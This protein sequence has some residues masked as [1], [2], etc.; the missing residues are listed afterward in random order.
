MRGF[1][2]NRR[3]LRGLVLLL[4]VGLFAPIALSRPADVRAADQENGPIAAAALARLDTWG[5]QCW[6][7][8]QEVVLQ[9][10]GRR[11]GFDY[12]QGFFEAGA[13]EVSAEEAQNGDII[14][15]ADDAD[16]NP[17]AS[18]PGMHTAIVLK[19][20]GG[21]RFDAVDSNQNWD[22]WVNLR[23]GYDPYASAARYGLQVRIYRIPGG[24]PGAAPAAAGSNDTPLAS[25]DPATVAADGGC[26]N[27][28]SA[29]GL[30][31]S[32][33]D[34]LPEGTGV[35]ITGEPVSKDGFSWVPVSTPRANGL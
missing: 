26:L 23:Y 11:V 8:M 9:A 27:L 28:R 6:T 16:T 31:A 19:N 10:T 5:G 34:C 22:E 25:G 30:S 18:Y 13:I 1:V 32:K 2:A 4:A 20:L 15:I 21:G 14:Q 7:F 12:R 17:W 35:T 29:P 24:G 3:F 33:L